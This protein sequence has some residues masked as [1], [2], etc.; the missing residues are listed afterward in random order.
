MVTLPSVATRGR[1]LNGAAQVYDVCEPL[2][3]LGQQAEI[4]LQLLTALALQDSDKIL[5]L[6]CGTG[7]LTKFIA[8]QLCAETGGIA[9]G[10]DAAGN[11]IQ[12]ARQKRGSET[13]RFEVA[14]AED[15]PF[16]SE[17]FDA[18]ISSLFFHHVPLD[19]KR[20]ALSEA[21]RVLKPGGRLVIAD[22]HTPTTLLGS[23]VSYAARWCLLQPEIGENIQG[24]LPALIADVGFLPATQI[25][26]Y[27]GYI[28][29]FA[30]Q[31]P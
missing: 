11:M 3:L 21:F 12:R 27:F 29:V 6:G 14:A 24:V 20:Q 2:V 9:I 10:I 25:A 19:L 7:V 22:M 8:D 28:A 26:T 17:Y 13:C 31:K 1:T 5:D 4:N 15:L 16:E 30:S 18:V 23:L